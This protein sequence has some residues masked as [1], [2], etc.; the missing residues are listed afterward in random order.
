M[1]SHTRLGAQRERGGDAASVGDAASRDD[2]LR[3]SGVHYLRHERHG[4]DAPGVSAPPR[5]PAPLSRPR[6]AAS[7]R[8]ALRTLPAKPITFTPLSWAAGTI[9]PG[10]AQRGGE[11]VHIFFQNHINLGAG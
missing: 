9:Q 8:W 1:P 3:T 10:F 4:G 6:P 11:H 7:C 2:G 5:C